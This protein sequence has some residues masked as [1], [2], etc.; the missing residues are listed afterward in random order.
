MGAGWLGEDGSVVFLP[1]SPH[2]PSAR[3]AP[4]NIDSTRII[5]RLDSH[6]ANALRSAA[7]IHVEATCR[8]VAPASTSR[9]RFEFYCVAL[10]LVDRWTL[11]LIAHGIR[12]LGW[13]ASLPNPAAPPVA[14]GFRDHC[15]GEGLRGLRHGRGFACARC[16]GARPWRLGISA[17]P[18]EGQPTASF[19]WRIWRTSARRCHCCAIV[20]YKCL[21]CGSPA[22]FACSRLSALHRL[23]IRH[24]NIRHAPSSCPR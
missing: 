23:A 5:I 16:C 8:R 14:A 18:F 1:S 10:A 19:T 24:L 17:L 2:A 12:L 15:Y 21:R 13:N 3:A 7:P 11:G 4:T 6:I 20:S 9:I 22:R